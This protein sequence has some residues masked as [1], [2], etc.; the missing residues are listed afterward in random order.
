M[1]ITTSTYLSP[2]GELRL[3]SL[4]GKLCMCDFILPGHE[5]RT[6]KRLENAFQAH[7]ID[8]ITPV[9]TQTCMQLDEYFAG[10]RSVFSIPLQLFGTPFQQQVWRI[11]QTVGYGETIS[12][13]EEAARL[14]RPT[15][16]RA[17]ANA[18]GANPISIIIPCHRIIA[19]NQK[20][21]GYGGGLDKKRFLLRLEQSIEGVRE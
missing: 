18:N 21:G 17:V 5:S 16:Y 4:E 6:V 12:Y 8:G 2:V 10:R 9:I 14:G 3:G 1:E 15:A 19:S 13:A 7:F 11:L 20:L